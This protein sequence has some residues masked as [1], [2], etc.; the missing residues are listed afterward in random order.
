[1]KR[2]Y[3]TIAFVL[4][5]MP[6]ILAQN[7]TIDALVA[8]YERAKS[9]T[10]AYIDAMPEDK[11]SFRPTEEV[12]TFAEQMLHLAQGTIGLAANGTGLD[13]IYKNENL[14]QTEAYQSKENV[15]KIVTDSFDF[16]IE[17]IKKMD[18]ATLDEI[19]ESS[20]FKVTRLGWIN[21]ALEHLVHHRGQCAV[22]LRIVGVTPPQYQLF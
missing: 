16:A 13:R 5:S 14:E 18:P 20:Q 10:L 9:L 19:I 8:D 6:L 7:N 17:G 21:K 1:M 11:Y 12:R 2:F 15:K 4:S 22:Y 3:L